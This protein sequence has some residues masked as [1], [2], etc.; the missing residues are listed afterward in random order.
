V[1][2]ILSL[3]VFLPGCNNNFDEADS[4]VFITVASVEGD[5]E[6]GPFGDVYNDVVPG[7]FPHTVKVT[8]SAHTNNQANPPTGTAYTTVQLS[9]Y[10]VTFYRTDAGADVPA[11]FQQA[12]TATVVAGTDTVIGGLTICRADQ[13]LQPP[14]YYLT[15]FSY[16][17]EPGTGFTAISCNCVI[18]FWGHTLAGDPVSATGTVA[19][20]FGDWANEE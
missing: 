12:L 9:S 10:R 14:L 2:C 20:N 17:F 3:I 11:G 4:P 15:P 5:S 18:D 19:I 7:F 13:N 16:G 8:L 6:P 1:A